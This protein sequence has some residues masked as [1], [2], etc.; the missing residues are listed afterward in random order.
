VG[1]LQAL[2]AAG[3][4]GILADDMGLGKT[5]Q[6]IAHLLHEKAAGRLERAALLVVP[7]S[8]LGNWRNELA[9][10]APGLTV[11][12]LHGEGRRTQFRVIPDADVVVTTYGL[13]QRDEVWHREQHYGWIVLDEAQSIKNPAS[14]MARVLGR[15]RSD[16][17]LCLTG[18]PVENHLGELWSLF[19]FLVPGYLGDRETFRR[20]FRKPIEQEG[21]ETMREILARRTRPFLLRRRK[22]DVV[23]ELPPKTQL[24]RPVEL[25]ARQREVYEDVREAM[26][27][28]VRNEIAEKGLTRSKFVILEALTRLRQVCCDP[29]LA[30]RGDTTLKASHSAKLA[31]LM[32]MLPDWVRDDHRVLV[33][34]QFTSMLTLIQEELRAARIGHVIL[35]G[36]TVD[37]ERP[38]TAFQAG[39]V[40]VFLISLRAGGAG[41]NLTAA[42]T[43]VHYDPWWNPQVENQATDRAYRIGQGRPV[44]VHKFVAAETVEEKIVAMQ[45]RKA[46][47][48]EGILRGAEADGGGEEPALDITEADVEEWFGPV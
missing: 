46:A 6:T 25:T 44:F 22:R 7:T 28:K 32:E 29:R 41:L 2:S 36:S 10:F 13:V 12:T 24:L 18:T 20:R 31:A 39:K 34:S 9:R 16:R 14:R 38:V 19:E 42:D 35:T 21:S 30:K 11:I 40:P 26:Q 45:E 43:V 47:L 48:A 33:F 4:N 1:W 27:I 15:L 17:R 37:R 23:R 3:W 5:L 8:L